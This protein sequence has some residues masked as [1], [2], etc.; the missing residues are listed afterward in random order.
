MLNTTHKKVACVVPQSNETPE[1]AGAQRSGI[2]VP[3][4]VVSND[5][6]DAMLVRS[7]LDGERLAFQRLVERHLMRA[8]GTARRLLGND[9]NADDVA[10]EAFVRL[11]SR[12]SDLDVGAAGVWPWLRRVIFNLCMDRR[13]ARR[14]MVPDALERLA[15]DENQHHDLEASDLARQVGVKMQD[16]PERQRDAINLFH[17]EGYTVKEIAETMDSTADAVESLLGRARRALKA[18]LKDEWEDLLPGTVSVPGDGSSRSTARTAE[19]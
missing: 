11:W 7:V 12:L 13:R 19:D 16:L 9:A 10:Q 17:Y 18:A 2:A 3:R 15:S 5:E 6:T 8:V 14:D 1:K 4:L